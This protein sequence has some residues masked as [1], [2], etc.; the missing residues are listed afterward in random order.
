MTVTFADT[1]PRPT[2]DGALRPLLARARNSPAPDGPL[3]ALLCRGLS[4]GYRPAEI[5]AAV[6]RLDPP[7]GALVGSTR[8]WRLVSSARRAVASSS[9]AAGARKLRLQVARRV[10]AR[11]LNPSTPDGLGP[12]AEVGA[13]V[14]FGVVG[15]VFLR[16]AEDRQYPTIILTSGYFAAQLGVTQRQAVRR[17]KTIRELGWVATTTPARGGAARYRLPRL[18]HDAGQVALHYGD[19][20]DAIAAGGGPDP[21]G[22]AILTALHPAWHY[23]LGA[24]A[25]LA[26]VANRAGLG[27]LGLS[28]KATASARDAI[29]TNLPGVWDGDAALAAELDAY[30]VP[31]GALA[32]KAE[33]VASLAV[34]AAVHREQL[35]GLLRLRVEEREPRAQSRALLKRAWRAV[36][37]PPNPDAGEAAVQA[38]A[39]AARELFTA[40]PVP[41][42]LAAVVPGTLAGQLVWLGHDPAV[43]DRVAQFV[44][45]GTGEAAL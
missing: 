42:A 45:S 40:H 34:A 29:Q 36:G 24:T 30:T 5:G 26:L 38:W 11:L 19:T 37:S 12:R 41:E 1:D 21:L 27:S 15:G 17:L 31:S 13:R 2:L 9:S 28:R 39:A 35:A 8:Y 32:R 6:K 10:V 22:E 23:G 18:G 3:L 43:A 20:I 4:L 16:E 14:A 33:A 7:L 25:W 44:L